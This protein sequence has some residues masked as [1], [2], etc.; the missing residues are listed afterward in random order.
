MRITNLTFVPSEYK[1]QVGSDIASGAV[2]GVE[3]TTRLTVVNSNYC[4]TGILPTR[5]VFLLNNCRSLDHD[6]EE[7]AL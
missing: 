5:G 7:V 4:E 3:D 1:I 2:D 6:R